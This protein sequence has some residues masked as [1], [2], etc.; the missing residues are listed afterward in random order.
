MLPH[1]DKSEL[2]KKKHDE[3]MMSDSTM[4]EIRVGQEEIS[5]GVV[6]H[7]GT[8]QS[9]QPTA[10]LRK[11]LPSSAKHLPTLSSPHQR[12]Q[13]VGTSPSA[14]Q[15]CHLMFLTKQSKNQRAMVSKL[16]EVQASKTAETFNYLQRIF[17]QK[18]ASKS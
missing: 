5:G 2:L 4:K 9:L 12:V 15:K 14:L 7:R 6:A 3:S 13:A 10:R 16:V 1:A 8:L 11:A 18:E 17:R